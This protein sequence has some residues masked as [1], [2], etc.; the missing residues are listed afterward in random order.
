MKRLRV[1]GLLGILVLTSSFTTAA[2]PKYINYSGKL[3]DKS[4][5][6]V[7]D[8]VYTMTFSIFTAASGG[9]A[10]WT[11]TYP[12]PPSIPGVQV[13][14]GAFNVVLGTANQLAIDFSQNYWLEMTWVDKGETF[15]RQQLNAVPYA[16]RTEYANS[17]SF[18]NTASAVSDNCISTP[19]IADGA[20]TSSKIGNGQVSLANM[21]MNAVLP[22]GSIIAWHKSLY[23]SLPSNWVECNGGVV[24]A[25][26][27]IAGATIPN[28]NG[29][30]R[31][32]RGASTS[33]TSQADA[34]GPHKHNETSWNGGSGSVWVPAAQQGSGVVVDNT[35]QTTNPT[36]GGDT[37]TRP[38][39]MSVVWIMKIK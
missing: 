22:I 23:S 16:I 24:P 8:G 28:L 38:L 37:E 15:Q 20:V 25:G 27:P 34:V 12:K 30:K 3:V 36:S 29:E 33:G 13:T 7:P 35:Y 26:S 32:L 1:I 18:A 4:G 14:N 6:I 39:N 21:D 19:K 5:N 10:V 17:A 11:E 9:V 31:F 2:V